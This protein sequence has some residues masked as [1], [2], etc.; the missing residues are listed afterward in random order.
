ML[1]VVTGLITAISGVHLV[2]AVAAVGGDAEA[3]RAEL[4]IAQSPAFEDRMP[5]ERLIT[6]WEHAVKAT[7]R[8]ELPALAVAGGT[9]HDER[10]LVAFCTSNQPTIGDALVILERYMPAVS[11]VHGWC[12]IASDVLCVR[13]SPPGPIDRFGWQLYLE[14][15]AL[16]IIVAARRLVRRNVAPIALRLPYAAPS[17]AVIAEIK[18]VAGV[19]PE[20]DREHCEAVYP[21]ALR[22]MPIEGARSQLAELVRARLDTFIAGLA[23]SVTTRARM[24]I[25]ELLERGPPTVDALARALA[26]SRRSLERALAAEQTTAATLFDDARLALAKAWLPRLSVDEVAA[27]LGYSDG[28]AFARAFRR[29]TGKPPSDFR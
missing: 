14:Y 15:E 2:R 23:T 18:R 19:A 3:T 26:M 13:A 4:G 28:R 17:T 1:G 5:V 21:L 22:D 12:G 10:S 24:R 29:W 27:R 6:A 20:F 7:G 8:R 25:P 16:D 9:T 11:D